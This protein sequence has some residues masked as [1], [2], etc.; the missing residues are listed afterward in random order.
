MPS[1]ARPPDLNPLL[2]EDSEKD[3]YLQVCEKYG[4][5]AELFRGMMEVLG[6]GFRV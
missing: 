2:P 1:K 6:F 4:I 5:L 3:F